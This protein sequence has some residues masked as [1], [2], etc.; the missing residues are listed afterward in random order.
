MYAT[1]VTFYNNIHIQYIYF[2]NNENYMARNLNDH[3]N[4]YFMQQDNMGRIHT[5]STLQHCVLTKSGFH[6][7]TYYIYKFVIRSQM[8]RRA[9]CWEIVSSPRDICYTKGA[10]YALSTFQGPVYTDFKEP[11]VVAKRK[12]FRKDHSTACTFDDGTNVALGCQASI[13]WALLWQ[14]AC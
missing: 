8:C 7:S 12:H 4:I 2:I 5:V 6:M 13:L 9:T 3:N 14:K 1:F 11:Q 10:V